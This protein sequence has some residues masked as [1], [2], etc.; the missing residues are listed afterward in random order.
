M[1]IQC[2]AFLAHH[3]AQP[4]ANLWAIDVVVVHPALVAGVVRRVDV[5]ALHLTG[6][7][8]QQ[9]FQGVQVV[10]LHNQ[11]ATVSVAAGQLRHSLQQAK[12]HLFVVLDDGIFADPVQCGHG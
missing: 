4:F 8:R 6:I 12:R 5:N 3:L 10:A 9:G 11:V 7:T 2:F 1:P